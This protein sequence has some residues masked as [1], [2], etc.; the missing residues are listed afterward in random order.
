MASACEGA[1]SLR[2]RSRT[3]ARTALPRP[4]GHDFAPR[5]GAADLIGSGHDLVGENLWPLTL[6]INL[7]LLPLRSRLQQ[8][9]LG[10]R[11][12]FVQRFQAFLDRASM[13]QDSLKNGDTF[14]R[15]LAEIQLCGENGQLGF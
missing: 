7:G 6:H 14:P 8:T 13:C 5:T 10:S 3:S 2:M 1:N 4:R 15:R 11:T 9:G 12:R